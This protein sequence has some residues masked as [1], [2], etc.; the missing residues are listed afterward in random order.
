M[1]SIIDRAKAGIDTVGSKVGGLMEN[2]PVIG[3]YRNKE[4]RREAD[5]RLRESIAKI[6]ETYRSK[7]TGLERDMVNAGRLR[8]L[9]GLERAVGRLQLL[10]DKIRT[11]AYGY[12]PFF[13]LDKVRE[14]ELER[15]ASFDQAIADRV[16]SINERITA[17]NQAI[18]ANEGVQ[19]ALD[20][21]LVTLNDLNEQFE[22][23]KAA[24]TEAGLV[25]VETMP[26]LPD[27][28]AP[29]LPDEPSVAP[30]ASTPLS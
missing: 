24:I 18:A 1:S 17:L 3:D 26:P 12:A 13:D 6:L 5:K 8:D 9:P 7:L 30:D 15:L 11:A 29:P 16:P 14:P 23:R 25:P 20:S 2:L 4:M 27:E 19:S 10:I 22:Q 21:L 28:P